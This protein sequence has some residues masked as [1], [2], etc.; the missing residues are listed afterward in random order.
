MGDLWA[1]IFQILDW[2]LITDFIFAVFGFWR[3]FSQAQVHA[4]LVFPG[5]ILT[6]EGEDE[7]EEK[8]AAETLSLPT[9][10]FDPHRLSPANSAT[11]GG[12]LRCDRIG[13]RHVYNTRTHMH[14]HRERT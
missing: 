12:P 2:H 14:T 9:E 6:E 1:L 11:R 3:F 4:F 7:E 13:T 8:T 5:D 10:I